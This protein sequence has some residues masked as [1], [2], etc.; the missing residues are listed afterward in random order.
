EE[1][2]QR[3]RD[4]RPGDRALVDVSIEGSDTQL[5]ITA[6]EIAA[7]G[8]RLRLISLQDIGRDLEATQL[9]AWQD[10]VRV[11]THAIMNSITPVASLSQT[12]AARSEQRMVP[13]AAPCLL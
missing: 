11:L 6:S 7:E 4:L 3:A 8:G 13:K 12:T 10:L 1:F 9:S 5:A 2:H